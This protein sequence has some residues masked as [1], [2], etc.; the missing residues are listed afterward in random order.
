MFLSIFIM[1]LI[2]YWFINIYFNC[3][4]VPLN[5]KV[6]FVIS[7]L[8][9][10][11]LKICGCIF[12]S[13]RLHLFD[14]K[15]SNIVKYYN[16]LKQLFSMWISVNKCNLFLWSKLYFQ[17]HYS[18]LQCHMI[19]RN[20]NNMLI[21]DQETFMIIINVENSCAAQYFCGNCDTFYFSGFTDE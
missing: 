20:H 15:Y 7:N 9:Q 3:N 11:L 12:F 21:Y 4:F 17:H 5:S 10:L 18:S 1:L 13:P 8:S 6:T 14:H 16:N 19:F 2:M